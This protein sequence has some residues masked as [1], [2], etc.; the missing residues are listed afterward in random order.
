MSDCE[1]CKD[2]NRMGLSNTCPSCDTVKLMEHEERERMTDAKVVREF[3]EYWQLYCPVSGG[4]IKVESSRGVFPKDRDRLIQVVEKK[5][6]D[7]ANAR[8]RELKQYEDH[9]FEYAHENVSG[10][11]VGLH[12][13]EALVQE[14]RN[15]KSEI[16]RLK[17]D[18]E[19]V[20]ESHKRQGELNDRVHEKLKEATAVIEKAADWIGRCM[21]MATEKENDWQ[22]CRE[23]LKKVRKG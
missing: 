17:Q 7:A 22:F 9:V 11:Y 14:H 1:R 8:I 23:Y 12:I 20:R 5:H 16:Q 13:A 15:L 3:L 21:C 18:L 10:E 4:V 19:I 6:I 2:W